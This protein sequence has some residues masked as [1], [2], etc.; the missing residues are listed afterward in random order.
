MRY[1]NFIVQS[2]LIVLALTCL[3]WFY[4]DQR[5]GEIFFLLQLIM[6]VWQYGG[7]LI[8]NRHTRIAPKSR[9]LKLASIYLLLLLLSPYIFAENFPGSDIVYTVFLTVP[10]WCLAGSLFLNLCLNY[11]RFTG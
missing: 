11:P 4:F 9:Y 10:P 8:T 6:G 1:T 7:C 3:A 5:A 2:I